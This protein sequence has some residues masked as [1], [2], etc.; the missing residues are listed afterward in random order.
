MKPS[1]LKL[2]ALCAGLTQTLHGQ[3]DPHAAWQSTQTIEVP[4]SGLVRFEL[5][6]ATLNASSP[7]L[8]DVRLVSPPGF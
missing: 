5:P 3:S 8:D 2:L 7:R 6:P 1:S 4:A